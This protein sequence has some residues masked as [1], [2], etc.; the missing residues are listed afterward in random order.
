MEN[1]HGIRSGFCVC[2]NAVRRGLQALDLRSHST[3]Y[4]RARPYVRR[5][6]PAISTH[7]RQPPTKQAPNRSRAWRPPTHLESSVDGGVHSKRKSCTLPTR[8]VR[9]QPHRTAGPKACMHAWPCTLL[10]LQPGRQ[11]LVQY[12]W[13]A[14][15]TTGGRT[16]HIPTGRQSGTRRPASSP[17]AVLL[18]WATHAK[19]IVA[20]AP[21]WPELHGAPCAV[22]AP[23]PMIELEFAIWTWAFTT[24]TAAMGGP[25]ML[26]WRG[27]TYC[28]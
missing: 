20:L 15:R 19:I 26:N 18:A 23:R 9:T 12:P 21:A 25:N 13:E 4:I 10:Q 5:P 14:G 27:S 17:F 22:R 2:Q 7:L 8:P 6:R 24:V 3:G 11:V 16:W 28:T 1:R